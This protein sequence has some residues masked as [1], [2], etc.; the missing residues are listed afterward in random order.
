MDFQPAELIRPRAY[1][2][3]IYTPE[4]KGWQ[5]LDRVDWNKNIVIE[6]GCGKG[7]WLIGQASKDPETLFIGIERTA[8]R[9][10]AFIERAGGLKHSN[11]IAIRADATAL[12]SQKVPAASVSALYFFYPN[13]LPLKKQANRRFFVG[14]SFKVFDDCLKE[15]GTICLASNIKGYASEAC[16]FLSRFWGY[17]IA[18]H[19]E[20]AKDENPRTAF[21]KK[22]QDQGQTLFELKAIKHRRSI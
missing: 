1:H 6:V 4:P 9:G 16:D 11:L 17:T 18:C 14:A 3:Y 12:I 8:L 20:R 15:H 2:P 10:G 21:E 7:D 22:Y 19:Q 5:A 13:P